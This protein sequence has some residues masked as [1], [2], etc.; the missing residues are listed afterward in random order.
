[1]PTNER[2][3]LSD[4]SD[5]ISTHSI[6]KRGRSV[7]HGLKD[8]AELVTAKGNIITKDGTLI[9]STQSDTSLSENIFL[10]PEVEAYYRNVYEDAKYECRHVFDPQA[11][12]TPKEEKVLVRKLDW[13][14]A[15]L[16]ELPDW[17]C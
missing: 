13:H 6:E 9:S 10:D 4:Q 2:P 17:L 8:S 5:S 15:Y 16:L 7:H 1:M 12:W 14:G 3:A 11:T